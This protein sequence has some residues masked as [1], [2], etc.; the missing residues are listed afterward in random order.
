MFLEKRHK[1][2]YFKTKRRNSSCGK[3]AARTVCRKE[4]TKASKTVGVLKN[5]IR[6]PKK[7]DK[8]VNVSSAC[9]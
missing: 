9:V 7:I 1:L 6:S 2:S 5:V 8:T 3:G 4:K